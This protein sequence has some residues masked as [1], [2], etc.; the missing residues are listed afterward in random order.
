M[1]GCRSRYDGG[2]MSRYMKKNVIFFLSAIAALFS[3]ALI[4]IPAYSSGDQNSTL[5]LTPDERRY[6]LSRGAIIFVSQTNYPPFEFRQPDGSMDGMCIELARWLSTEAGF[7]AKFL[8]MPFQE[9]QQAVLSGKADVIT[10]LFFSEKRAQSFGFTGTLFQVPASIFVKSERPDISTLENLRGKRIAIQRGDYAKEFL[11]SKGIPFE[12]IPA[13]SFAEATDAVLGDRADALIGDE[14]IVLYHLYSNHLTKLAKKVGEPLYIGQNCMAAKEG[15]AL[16]HSILMKSIEHARDSGAIERISRKW[17]GTGYTSRENPLARWIPYLAPA[18]G[19]VI[20]VVLMVTLWNVRLR[21]LV[22]KRTVELSESETKYRQ[23]VESANSIILKW[24]TE[25]KVTFFNE[26]AEKYFGFSQE[27]IIGRN[28]IGTIVPAIEGSSRNLVQIIQGIGIDPDA[29]MENESENIRKNGERVWISWHNHAVTSPDGTMQEILSIGQDITERKMAEEEKRSLKEQ[30]YQIQKIESIGRL[31]GGIAHDFNNLL[32]PILGYAEMIKLTMPGESSNQSKI[33]SIISAA[34][35]A[36]ILTRQLLSFSRKQV[37]EMKTTN[38]NEVVTSFYEILRRTIRENI[39]IRLDLNEVPVC[40]K[41]DRNQIEQVIM[42]LLVNAQGAIVDSG[43]ITIGTAPV[44][45][46]EEFARQHAGTVTGRYMM[47]VVTDSG[48]GMDQET[49]AHIYEPFFTTKGVGEGSGLGLATVY[50]IVKQHNGYIWASSEIG[51]GSVFKLYF[52]IVDGAPVE[53]VEDTSEPLPF[54]SR[55]RTILL[56]ED[57][58]MV[59]T[60]VYDF[61]LV[62]G[63]NVLVEEGPKQ[64][65]KSCNGRRIDLLI[66][67]VVMPDMNGSELYQRLL[68]RQHDLKVLFMSGYTDNIIAPHGIPEQGLNFIQKPFAAGDLSRKIRQALA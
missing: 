35:K 50:G 33:N 52:P 62:H 6:L 57:D 18:G 29:F 64:A 4:T 22:E 46:D 5:E 48:C 56:V 15:N 3:I 43:I 61:L 13:S 44:E 12:L 41:A 54:D 39:A 16:L 11:E 55:G 36:K 37:L 1:I 30:L 68:K 32:T 23:L 28:V 51:R 67:D 47:L 27:E 66:T 45:I 21:H 19:G 38:L 17:L 24:T 20:A 9:A 2:D 25:G 31:A 58:E 42:N 53:C 10:S 7:Q 8:H 65:L 60:L 14:Q 63:F 49:L 59:R 34:E 26:F 40:I